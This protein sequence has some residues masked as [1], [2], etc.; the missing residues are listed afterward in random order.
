MAG[1]SE[2]PGFGDQRVTGHYGVGGGE[3]I[4]C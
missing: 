4:I 1:Y 3:G 2:D